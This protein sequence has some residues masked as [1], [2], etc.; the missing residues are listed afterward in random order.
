MI[1]ARNHFQ[2]TSILVVGGAG[3]VGSHMA[4]MLAQNNYEVIILDNLSTGF[5]D[6]ARFGHLVEGDLADRDLL[7]RIF[8]EHSVAAVLHF[9]ALSQVS[10]SMRE[11]ARYYH[12]NVTNTQNLLDSMGRHGIRRFIFSSTAAIFGEPEYTPIDEKHRQCPINP[13][14]RSKRMVEEML[15]DYDRSYSMRFVS[16]RYFNAAGADPEGDLGER[17]DPE[18][19]LIPF[20]LQVA[21]GRRRHI[22]IYGDDYP[23]PDG[24]CIRDFIHVWDLCSAHLLALEHLLNDGESNSFNLGN[25]LGYS[26]QDVVKTARR[27]TGRIILEEIQDRRPGDPAVLVADSQNARQKLGWRQRFRNLDVIIQ[28]AWQWELKQASHKEKMSP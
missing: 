3:Y 23:T 28:H 10:E 14:G 27:I 6:A 5:R 22:A 12:N 21:S 26:V 2:K 15:E 1:R 19:H 16:L 25:G 4:K 17:H 20:V 11:P 18:S 24:T 9:A 7:D 8:S 13:Y